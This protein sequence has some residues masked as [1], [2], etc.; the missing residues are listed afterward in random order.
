MPKKRV[1][2]ATT[3]Y[4]FLNHFL[5]RTGR[6]LGEHYGGEPLAFPFYFFLL[7]FSKQQNV[8]LNLWE[9]AK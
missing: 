3:I 4:F 6:M 5:P 7:I 8:I 9:N 1:M 2:K